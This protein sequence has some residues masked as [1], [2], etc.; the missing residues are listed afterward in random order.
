MAIMQYY[1]ASL[2]TKSK[3]LTASKTMD[4]SRVFE[5]EGEEE[6]DWNKDN[7]Q[8]SSRA[9]IIQTFSSIGGEYTPFI[10]YAFTV[11][12]ILGVGCLGIPFAFL[13]SGLV[14][15]TVLIVGLSFISY[16]T[17]M[18][19]AVATQQE[20][21]I[22]IYHAATNPFVMSPNSSLAKRKNY[23]KHHLRS[24]EST[25]LVTSSKGN[26]LG[27][28]YASI[29]SLIEQS[30]TDKLVSVSDLE[31]FGSSAKRKGNKDRN[32]RKSALS[33]DELIEGIK[34]LE[35]TD[36]AQEFLGT[37]GKIT[38]QAAL[39]ALAYVGLLAYT[40]VFNNTF[41]SQLWPC[42]PASLPP[43]LFGA[44]VIP[45]SCLDLAEQMGTQVLMSLLRFLSLGI[46]LVGTIVALL[47]DFENSA[48]HKDAILDSW[49]FSSLSF[50]P[51]QS[52]QSHV[53]LI[54]WSGFGVMFTTSIFSQLFQHSVPGLIRPLSNDDKKHVPRIFRNALI[55]TTLLYVAIGCTTVL[56]FGDS[57]SQSVNLNFV[58]FSWGL[59]ADAGWANILVRLLAFIVVLFPALD[60]L[61]VFPLI[62]ITLGNSLHAAFRHTIHV[63]AV[64][65]LLP[66]MDNSEHHARRKVS[67]TFWRLVA[68]IPPVIGS[69]FVH[70]LVVSLQI[71]GLCG[72]FVAL[73][74]PALLHLQTEHRIALIPASMQTGLLFP[75]TY[76]R[77]L[78]VYTV[79]LLGVLALVI[80]CLQMVE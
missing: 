12:Y 53:Q 36:L 33:D 28:Y 2:K 21:S 44:V 43:L 14:L 70:D 80:S 19:I 6:G 11:N 32:R 64:L 65:S 57:L 78:Y 71:A 77:T 1:G 27:Q 4:W 7:S 22:S 79:V 55:T 58:G 40:Q 10:C 59:T 15:G 46:L 45:L 66:F 60:T 31:V 63:D 8:L 24:E 5:D 17:V 41:I 30:S 9:N 56:Y 67:R 54:R 68:S 18:W 50:S 38:Y 39:I 75:D 34:E 23:V 72:I 20:V 26:T 73:I 16:V 47:V 76:N 49:S 29:A 52:S 25:S 13:Q 48:M 62:A 51:P 74:M 69:F 42:A 37:I 3:S 35:V 61:S